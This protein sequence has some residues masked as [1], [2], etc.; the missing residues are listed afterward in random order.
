M[1]VVTGFIDQ[2]S[3][4][5]GLLLLAG[6]FAAFVMERFP[7]VVVGV[8]G[9]ATVL[10][11]GFVS[12]G[13]LRAVFSNS[14]PVAIGALFILSGALVRTGSIDSVLAFLV[15]R[16][17]EKPK[18]VLAEVLGGAL[19]TAS[20]V[21]NTPVVIIMI[22]VVKRL[23]RALGVASTRL[24]IPLSYLAIMGGTLTLVGTSTNLLVDGVARD[25]GQPAFG[26]FEITGVG[27]IAALSGV[28]A[29]LVLGPRMLPDRADHD[30][31]EDEGHECLSELRVLPAAK[32]VGRAIGE[33]RAL[34]PN[35]V[36]VIAVKR[37][38]DIVR[39]DLEQHVLKAGDRLVVSCSPRELAAF[40]ASP[41]F[42]VGIG[43]IEGGVARTSV[44]REP[45]VKLYEATI[46]P[47]HPSIGRHLDEIPILSRFRIRVLGI[48]RARHLPGPDMRTARLRAA[49]TLLIAAAPPE[50]EALR[51]D[52]HLAGI[53]TS[54]AVPYRRAKAPIAVLTLLSTV[55]LAAAGI[56][57]IEGLAIIGV[58]VVLLTKTI[59]P[60]EAWASIDGSLLVLI[61]SMLAIGIGFENAGSVD[62]IVGWVAPWLTLAPMLLVII[63]VYALTSFLTEVVTNNAVAVVLTP[64]V[65]ALS[66]GL[67]IDP[68]PLL[69]AVMM[70]AS[71]SFATPIGY[72]TNTLVY[73]AADYRFVD[74]IKIGIP[75]NI[76]VGLSAC[77]A[78]Y[79][80]F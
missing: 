78:I 59:D 47:T 55:I 75:M 31:A 10:L 33:I 20:V 45:D 61:F 77:I 36:R 30:V 39:H 1:G 25:A 37:R 80:L 40:A 58:A 63:T 69:V 28:L 46:A 12:L 76:I 34:K 5:I 29:L 67:G 64:I 16:A 52:V 13:E 65:I 21:N 32:T 71:A 15:K 17:E 35:R 62:L 66:N 79:L 70:A 50:L 48:S 3:A 38:N 49:D 44:R 22:P 4:V 73:A 7:P 18:R 56:M 26:I 57:P 72:Q 14:A 19:G 6:I 24:L 53:S 11:F 27:L 51:E 41:D 2:H 43:G 42:E 68:R 60:G 74:F 8:A 9:A 23:G 54:E